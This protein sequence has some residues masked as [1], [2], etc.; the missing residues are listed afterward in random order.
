M[1]IRVKQSHRFFFSYHHDSHFDNTK[2]PSAPGPKPW[3]LVG[4]LLQVGDQMHL[5]LTRLG[6]QYGD[7]FKVRWVWILIYYDIIYTY[8]IHEF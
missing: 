6:L 1:A 8:H 5:S 4:N 7:V 3:P 2:F